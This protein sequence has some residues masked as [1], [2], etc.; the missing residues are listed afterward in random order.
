MLH[1]KNIGTDLSWLIANHIQLG[2]EFSLDNLDYDKSTGLQ[3]GTE[4]M[5]TIRYSASL[6]YIAGSNSITVK[7]GKTESKT[8]TSNIDASLAISLR[9]GNTFSF[10][11]TL[12]YQSTE[13]F[14]D[15]SISK[16]YNAYLSSEISFIPELF[17]LSISG[18]WT[19]TDNTYNDSTVLSAGGNLNLYLAKIFKNK[20]QPM[21]SLRGKYEDYKNGDNGKSDVT[22]YLQADI[23]F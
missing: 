5:D 19:K 8:F 2:A 1:T 11:P 3:T 18:S 20:I 13:N 4:D 15:N 22:V 6:G 14:S 7:L 12:S 9:A 10:N 17:S 21:L 16:I 23:S